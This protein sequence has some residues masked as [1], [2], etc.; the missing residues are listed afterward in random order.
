MT[1]LSDVERLALHLVARGLV[2][3]AVTAD[4]YDAWRVGPLEPGD[5][6]RMWR[7]GITRRQLD[8][9]ADRFVREP[10]ATAAFADP[11]AHHVPHLRDWAD[12]LAE[13]PRLS[14]RV[15]TDGDA[16][17]VVVQVE[18]DAVVL[19]RHAARVWAPLA[20]ALEVAVPDR[21][22]LSDEEVWDLLGDGGRALTDAGIP[23]YWPRELARDVTASTVVG[24]RPETFDFS[25]Q[26]ALG[27]EV[28]SQRE[29]D[30]LAEAQRPVVRLRDRRALVS[31]DLVRKARDR[32]LKPLT[33][34]EALGAALTGQAEVDGEWVPVAGE[35][36]ELLRQRLDAPEV[37]HPAR[38]AATLRDYQL[39]GLR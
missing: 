14:L 5:V 28:L 1:D 15:E 30:E 7:L 31:P 17:S 6:E 25:W 11:T 37:P 39:R 2:V 29:M 22:D 23:V 8:E 32:V 21:L 20:R 10:G 27:G 35:P 16:V 18:P 38:L 36:L 34:V 33:A 24:G 9:V 12:A 13:P 19:I 4:G 3:P 26:L